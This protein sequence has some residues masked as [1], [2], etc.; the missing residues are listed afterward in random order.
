MDRAEQKPMKKTPIKVFVV[1]SF[2]DSSL[3]QAQ[4]AIDF[5]KKYYKDYKRIS[6]GSVHTGNRFDEII[7]HADVWRSTDSRV[8]RWVN[9]T[10]RTRL[11]PGGKYVEL[12]K[13]NIHGLSV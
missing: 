13:V 6:T 9:E 11:R 1:P 7:V 3:A 4:H 8:V 2:G 5:A 12:E 10:L